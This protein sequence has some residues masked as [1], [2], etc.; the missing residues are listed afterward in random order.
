[1]KKF[2]NNVGAKATK[3]MKKKG[4]VAQH[5]ELVVLMEPPSAQTSILRVIL[6]VAQA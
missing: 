6:L 2:L 4:A 1:M 3:L 5:V